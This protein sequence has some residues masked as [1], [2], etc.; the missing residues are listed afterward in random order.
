MVASSSYHPTSLSLSRYAAYAGG[1]LGFSTFGP[2]FVMGLGYFDEEFVASIVF[3]GC[4]AVAGLIGTPIGTKQ[5][6]MM[7]M[8]GS[9]QR[10][11]IN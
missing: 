5:M 8:I 6:M 4:M 1:I 11:V 7:M 2:Q 3:G 9:E 10:E